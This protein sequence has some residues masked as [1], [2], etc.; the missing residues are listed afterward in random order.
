MPV[1]SGLTTTTRWTRGSRILVTS[2]QPPVTSNATRS[3]RTRLSANAAIPWE[4]AGTRPA[5]L[6]TPSSHTAT[7]QKSRCTSRPIARPTH[8]V[9]AIPHLH[10]SAVSVRENQ[11][12]G[13]T[14]RYELNRSIQASRRRGRRDKPGL[15]AH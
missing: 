5:E 2:Q 15:E 1:S 14:D 7:S 6:I 11:R 9:T 4:V 10:H 3:E 12:D 13:D 8:L